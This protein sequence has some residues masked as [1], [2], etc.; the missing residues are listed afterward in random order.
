[1]PEITRLCHVCGRIATVVCKLCGRP[2][3]DMH[4]DQKHGVCTT[5]KSGR[6]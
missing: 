6:M 4:S 2:V 5:C 1:M 3:C